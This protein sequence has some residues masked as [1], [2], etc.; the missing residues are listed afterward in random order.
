MPGVMEA[1]LLLF[2]VMSEG[3]STYGVGA[4]T[5]HG[6]YFVCVCAVAADL[7]DP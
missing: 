4:L 2:C 5:E 3:L 6:Y 1:T 7:N